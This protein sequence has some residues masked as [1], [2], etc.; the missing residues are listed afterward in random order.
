[1]F[2]STLIDGKYR[3]FNARWYERFNWIEYS[4]SKDLIFCKA[5]R[6]FP[7]QHT[8]ATFTKEGFKNWKR[9]GQVCEKH[10]T[11]KVHASALV[12]LL[13]YKQSHTNQGSGIVLNQMHRDSI[14]F[15]ER[16]RE[17]VKVVLDVV[18]QCAK[19]EIPLRG[20]RETQ[21]ALNKGN[22]LALFEFISKK[23]KTEMQEQ[24]RP[25]YFAILADEFKDV[26]KRELVAVCVRFIHCGT[27]KEHALG[28]VKTADLSAQGISR[29]I[30]EILEPLGLDPSLCVGFCFD[31]ASVMSGHRGGVQA[32]LK[33]TFPKAVY[34]HCNSHRL[35]LVL[36]AAAQASGHE[37][38]FHCHQ[39]DTQLLHWGPEARLVCGASEGDASRTLLQ[40]AGKVM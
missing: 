24:P 5:C 25:T 33:E 35:N 11:S 40:G 7:E 27:I 29:R 20:H 10:Q 34:V 23:T 26:S 12:K 32:I 15:I 14:S 28:F 17:H 19:M 30:L 3:S 22:F 31:G 39:S 18:M 6:H 37:Y 4:Q 8:E 38:F 2:P 1:A 13:S 16:N 21:E 36:C 9:I